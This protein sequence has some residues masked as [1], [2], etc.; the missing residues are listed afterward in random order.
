MR[1][2][3]RI[4]A[5]VIR[6]NNGLEPFAAPWGGFRMSGIGRTSGRYGLDAVTE[7]KQMNVGLAP[8][9]AAL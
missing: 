3:Q 9:A 4:R 5:G 1:V 8:L 2:G 7:L 6:I